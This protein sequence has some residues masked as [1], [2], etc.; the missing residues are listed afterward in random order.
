MKIG[1]PDKRNALLTP[2]VGLAR[3]R[4]DSAAHCAYAKKKTTEPP[5]LS[6]LGGQ[7][8]TKTEGY[9][10]IDLDLASSPSTMLPRYSL[11]LRIAV[12]CAICVRVAWNSGLAALRSGTFLSTA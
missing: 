10:S 6:R 8:Y 2:T 1:S 7:E 9:S 3:G 11:P 5:A 4:N 12:A